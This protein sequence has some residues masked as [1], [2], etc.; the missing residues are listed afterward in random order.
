MKQVVA[1]ILFFFV[2]ACSQK[3]EQE[4]QYFTNPVLSGFYPDPSICKVGDDF[5]LVTSTFAY[6]PGLPILHSKDLVNWR[7]IG[8]AM[9]RPEQL[10]LDGHGVSRGL[11]AP[12]IRYHKGLYYITCTLIDTGGNFVITA[13]DPAGPWS[14]PYWLPEV[15]GIDP[16]MYFDE[17]KAYII[18]NSIPPDNE[19]LYGGH[20]TI[21]M[22]EFDTDNMRVTGEEMLLVNGGVDITKKPVWIEAPH[23]FKK[24]GYYYL[25]CAEGGTAYNHSEVVF[26]SENA[27]GPYVPWDKNPILTQRHLDPS[28]PNPIT[29]TG[30]ADFVELD[31]GEWW[32]VFLGC[33]PYADKDYFNTGRETFLTPVKWVDGWPVINPDFEEVQYRYP[34]PLPGTTL[35]E[36]SYSRF[37]YRY[38]FDEDKLHYNFQFLRTVR[39]KWYSFSEKPGQ[40]SLKVRPETCSG[41]MNPSFVAHRQTHLSGSASTAITFSPAVE[42]E[43]A[44]LMVFQNETHFYFLTK[45]IIEDKPVVALYQSSPEGEEMQLLAHE[46]IQGDVVRLKIETRKDTYAFFFG[47]ADDDWILLKEGVDARFLSTREAGGF[48]G[49][50]Y[51]MYATSNGKE[52]TSV[53]HFDWFETTTTDNP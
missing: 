23:I 2:F 9:D 46:E 49:C 31:N 32:A 14:D 5:Y 16:S 53:A 29:T 3:L 18:Y 24:D 10:N 27:K 19:P 50:M 47:V 13:T 48:V 38:E 26:R 36:P 21:R 35:L 25:I 41:K 44:G 12:S 7:T 30:H 4:V 15:N 28:R 34:V 39:E 40:L 45:T 17:D 51:A 33:R 42:N 8:F 1:V 43:M 11:F 20:R 22:F 6:Y 52:S 37:N